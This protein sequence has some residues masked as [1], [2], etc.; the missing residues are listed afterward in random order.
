MNIQDKMTRKINSVVLKMLDDGYS[1]REIAKK[2]GYSISKISRFRKKYLL[3]A[4][5]TGSTKPL[6]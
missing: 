4:A 1:Y 2:T 5:G 3:W 6:I